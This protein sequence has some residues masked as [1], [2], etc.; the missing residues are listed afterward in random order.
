VARLQ[1]KIDFTAKINILSVLWSLKAHLWAVTV[2]AVY[3]R[4]NYVCICSSCDKSRG[5][6]KCDEEE[7]EERHF[8]AFWHRYEMTVTWLYE[9]LLISICSLSVEDSTLMSI[10]DQFCFS[11]IFLGS[12][13]QKSALIAK[14]AMLNTHACIYS[15]SF[16]SWLRCYTASS[17]L[18][19]S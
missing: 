9:T 5:N 11:F 15:I 10:F 1:A 7:E 12:P 13:T 3:I 6:K 2:L 18:H 19:L 17:N 16:N 8:L 4:I 14:F